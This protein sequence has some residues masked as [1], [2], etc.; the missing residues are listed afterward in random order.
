MQYASEICVIRSKN[1]AHGVRFAVFLTCWIYR[2]TYSIKMH[3]MYCKTFVLRR[4]KSQNFDVSRL[5][6]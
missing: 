5:V 2:L 4:T 6:S 1:Y 3:L